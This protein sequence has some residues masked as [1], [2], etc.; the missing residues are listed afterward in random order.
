M[1]HRVDDLTESGGL[2]LFPDVYVKA[3][4]KGQRHYQKT[5]T[6]DKCEG[7]T[8][9]FEYRLVVGRCYFPPKRSWMQKLMQR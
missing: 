1:V 4:L 2:E 3:K 8:A 6:H 9:V 5:D 7:S